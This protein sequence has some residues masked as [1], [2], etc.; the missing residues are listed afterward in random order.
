MRIGLRREYKPKGRESPKE[1]RR[2]ARVERAFDAAPQVFL[3]LQL[4]AR[5]LE[6]ERFDKGLR[7]DRAAVFF[8]LAISDDNLIGITPRTE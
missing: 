3:V 4:C 1:P 7:Q 8:A 6:A 5:E 2:S